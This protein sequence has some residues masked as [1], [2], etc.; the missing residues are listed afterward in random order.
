MKGVD[1]SG[2]RGSLLIVVIWA[3]VFFT[4]L[5][6]ACYS[7]LNSRI[8]LARFYRDRLLAGQA[9]YSVCRLAQQELKGDQT[10]YDTLW[11]CGRKRE[12]DFGMVQCS[13]VFVDEAR[14]I[15]INSAPVQLLAGLPGIADELAQKI[16]SPDARPFTVKEELRAVEGIDPAI[17]EGIRDSVTVYGNGRIN[18]NTASGP[19]LQ[20][21]GA[22]PELVRKILWYRKGAD[23]KEGTQDDG[24]FT[25]EGKI[26][27]ALDASIG[28]TDGEKQLLLLLIG[29]GAL[30]V[31]SEMFTL[32]AAVRYANREIASYSIVMDKKSVREWRER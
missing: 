6:S 21:A 3:L 15:N 17:Y 31:S 1:V 8:R 20:A 24:I 5:G 22:S 32:E 7:I 26:V 11:E 19:V 4:F 18:V 30:S 14:K 2:K 13:Y 9:A 12:V 27:S 28:L 25:D 29:R 10:P 23:E 16:S